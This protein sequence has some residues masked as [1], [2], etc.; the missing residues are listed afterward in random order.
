M[1]ETDWDDYIWPTNA[2]KTRSSSFAEFRKT[3]FH[4]GIDISTNM[5]TGYA[6]YASRAGWVRSIT[7]QPGGYGWIITLRHPDGYSTCYAHLKGFPKHIEDAYY[8]KLAE[9]GRSFGYAEWTG[10]EIPVEKGEVIAYTGSTGAGPPHLHF[11]IRDI[12][13]NPVNPELGRRLRLPDSLPPTFVQ[14]CWMPLSAKSLVNGQPRPLILDA[15]H[16]AD[17]YRIAAVPVLSGPVGLLVR[18]Y[19]RSPSAQ[20]LPTPY[21]MVLSIDGRQF[22]ESRFDRIQDTHLWHIRI[23]R[24]HWLMKAAKGEFRKLY[25]ERGNSLC[26]YDDRGGWDGIVSDLSCEPG[27]HSAVVEAYDVSGNRAAVHFVFSLASSQKP[28]IETGKDIVSVVVPD[29]RNVSRVVLSK[30]G[31]GGGWEETATWAGKEI[32]S[33]LG[34]STGGSGESWKV[35]VKDAAKHSLAVAYASSARSAKP[36][37]VSLVRTMH[38]DEV[39]YDFRSSFPFDALPE[40]VL[41]QGAERRSAEVFWLEP[42]HV[43]AVLQTWPSFAGE[44]AMTMKAVSGGHP[45]S[46]RDRFTAF[47]VTPETGGS[48]RSSDGA[49]IVSFGKGDVYRPMLI[50]VSRVEG[51]EK[52]WYYGEPS[53]VPIAGKALIQI[54]SA[55]DATRCFIRAVHP[56]VSLRYDREMTGRKDMVGGRFGRLLGKYAVVEDGDG[57][58]IAATASRE[59]IAL[60]IRDTASGVDLSRISVSVDGRILPLEYSET[61]GVFILPRKFLRSSQGETAFVEAFD[62]MGNRTRRSIVLR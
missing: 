43:R 37:E 9:I 2:S 13:S 42:T 6:V 23:D 56:F 54:R 28:S 60:R 26:V 62:M 3:H 55:G 16:S 44:A 40:V 24:D 10:K 53:D 17:G 38:F 36:P 50:S 18:A 5:R 12:A 19:D 35:D 52:T 57:P 14:V 46:A 27:I 1:T 51:E 45:V 41:E 29:V 8:A 22:F 58:E 49:C 33:K 47:H 30:R 34:C 15:V 31:K 11:E 61:K 59:G 25:R 20:D 48:A 21:R 32:R 4:A 7:F 39:V